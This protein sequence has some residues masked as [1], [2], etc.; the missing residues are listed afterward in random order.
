MGNDYLPERYDPLI[1][2]IPLD[3]LRG[4]LAQRRQRIAHAA[5]AM[6]THESFITRL[7]AA[8]AA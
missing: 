8:K 1:D 3:R 2:R 7:L 4:G 5:E 6:P